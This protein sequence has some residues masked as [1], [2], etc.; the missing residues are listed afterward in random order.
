[1]FQHAENIDVPKLELKTKN[2]N[3]S[4]FYNV[5]GMLYPS[6]TSVLS[7]LSRDSIKKWRNRVGHA[8]ADAIS[9]KASTRGTHVHTICEKYINNEGDYL[10]NCLPDRI[11]MFKS[12]QP[13]LDKHID[14]VHGQELAL[15]S[16][17]LNVAG[18]VDC[19]AE[20][21]GELAVIDFKTSNKT[22]KKEWIANYFMQCSAYAR[23]YYEHTGMI[24]KKV[25]V[26]I[27]VDQD[28]PQVF[29]EKVANWIVPFK[30]LT[31]AYR[32]ENGL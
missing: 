5:N 21:D 30:E 15:Y 24:I 9:R 31:L 29:E 2:V 22:K 12:I 25:V 11:S 32:K 28:H 27:A 3:G 17:W 7:M 1:M 14:N 26:V 6:V 18:R 23:M 19:I 4:R 13:I 20:W 16:D 10:D 8:K